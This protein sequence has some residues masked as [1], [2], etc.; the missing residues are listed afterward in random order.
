MLDQGFALLAELKEDE[1]LIELPNTTRITVPTG[2]GSTR[3]I[4]VGDKDKLLGSLE[5]G[6]VLER[7]R[8]DFDDAF[9]YIQ[10]KTDTKVKVALMLATLWG[11]TRDNR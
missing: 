10:S 1:S 5:K 3:S 11:L 6:L 4:S 7:A 2:R 8:Q 9:A